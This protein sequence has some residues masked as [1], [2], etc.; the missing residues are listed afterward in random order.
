MARARLDGAVQWV[1]SYFPE[2]SP[3]RDQWLLLTFIRDAAYSEDIQQYLPYFADQ[4]ARYGTLPAAEA[5]FPERYMEAFLGKN[6]KQIAEIIDQYSVLYPVI[7][8]HAESLPPC[9][10]MVY[11]WSEARWKEFDQECIAN[12][13]NFTA[14]ELFESRGVRNEQTAVF[15]ADTPEGSSTYGDTLSTIVL[16]PSALFLNTKS[17]RF[18]T[19][20]AEYLR[21]IS[22]ISGSS[23]LNGFCVED[24]CAKAGVDLMTDK[25]GRGYFKILNPEIIQHI[26]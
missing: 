24:I 7:L 22:L 6:S 10:K 15:V 2:A 17:D 9:L 3:R 23:R 14:L 5:P 12:D 25:G 19:R 16:D 1:L 20:V 4:G 21:Q 18:I 13:G 8:S 26:S 11:R